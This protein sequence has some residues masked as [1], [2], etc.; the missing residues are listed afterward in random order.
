MKKLFLIL[1]IMAMCVPPI[2]AADNGRSGEFS[3]LRP[4]VD[5]YLHFDVNTINAWV[6]N[7]GSIF[8]HPITGD[9]GFEWP[10][11]SELYSVYASGLWIGAKVNGS[12]RVAVAEYS[13]EYQPGQIDNTTHQP[14]DPDDPIY[15]IYKLSKGDA[16]PQLITDAGG[17]SEVLG[18]QMLWCVYNDGEASIHVNAQTAPLYVEVQQTIFGFDRLG[19][20]GNTGF[21]KWL[22]INKSGN[23]LDDAY[24]AVWV[25]PDLGDSGDDFVGCDTS[26]SLGFCYN[27]SNNDNDYGA[28][29]PAVG[30]DF[31]QGPIVPSPGDTALVS[32]VRFPEYKNLPM[33]S[34]VYYNNSNEN[35]GNPQTGPEVYNYMQAKWRDGTPITAGGTGID[36][37]N[38]PTRF[39]FTGEPEAG[40]G[41]L[42]SSPADRRF[43]MSTG[44]FTMEPFQDTNGNGR[45]D[46][47]EPGVQ[48]VVAG[49][50]VARGLDNRN[51]VSLL[52]FY[53]SF[54]QN[55]YD[56]NFEI[57]EAPPIPEVEVTLLDR[58]IVFDWDN[59]FN[60]NQVEMYHEF[61]KELQQDASI[62]PEEKY[63]D[64]Q[65][66]IVYQYDYLDRTNAKVIGTY[67]IAD[68]L[69]N[70]I[71]L[72]FDPSTGQFIPVLRIRAGDEGIKRWMA[73]REDK[74]ATTSDTRLVNGK[75]YWFGISAYGYNEHSVP[76][77]IESSPRLLEVT[78]Q[79]NSIGT[80]LYGSTEQMITSEKEGDSDGGAF[81]LIVDPSKLNGHDYRVN[82]GFD[83]DNQI[84]WKLTDVSLNTVRLDSQ[85]FQAVDSSETSY[86]LAGGIQW[87]VLGPVAGI[88]T[89]IPGP[90]GDEHLYNGWNFSGTRWV[91]WED[92]GGISFG[93]SLFNGPDF[94][95]S[96]IGPADYTDVELRWAGLTDKSDL[97]G[98]VMAA[99]SQTEMPDRWSKAYVYRRDQ[100]Y[101]FVGMGDI[102]FS[103]WDV[104]SDRRLNICFVE[105]ANN[106]NAN[107]LWD[108][109]WNGTDTTFSE[110]GGREYI[111]IMTSDYDPA[112]SLYDDNNFGPEADVMY[113]IYPNERSSGVSHPYLEG[114]WDMQI[115]ASNVNTPSTVYYFSTPT[116]VFN[117]QS[118]AKSDMEKINVFPNPYYATHSGE[119]L[120]TEKWIE[121]THLPPTCTIRIFNLAGMLIRTLERSSVTDRTWEKW[122]LQNESDLPVASGIYIYHIE[123]PNVGEKTGKM[124]IFMPQER[125]DTF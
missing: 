59:D 44:P 124:A 99:A 87:K 37:N 60:F 9:S 67:D 4:Q 80:R 23:S 51:S 34:F 18:D 88:N 102:P 25:D 115:Y 33:T 70:I 73:V 32:G 76:K 27:S 96:T 122:N 63:F 36:P 98:E 61:N 118:M 57:P 10:K 38:P 81:G 109:G 35:N 92:H 106:G 113:A 43:M 29:P 100:G 3:F 21:I 91:S 110:N 107:M 77:V 16:V 101:A 48:E 120:L 97:T 62:P 74:F 26:L 47:G 22:V 65:G 52:K 7:Y 117:D 82:F 11:G 12:P 84:Y 49:V 2:W 85:Y 50:A 55:T 90:F 53:D 116:A 68:G 95:S 28:S 30:Y 75:R 24:L 20:L 45:P 17:P 6:T 66:Y 125:L 114:S 86:P 39:M 111:F 71:D 54:V 93:G 8:R 58:E 31:L 40:T 123:I 64:F 79:G 46:V 41:W 42:D 19:P 5:H 83:A 121:F 104:E 14:M 112:G 56:A 108:M 89:N 119:R 1:I 78:P 105:D 103:A 15:M 69:G 72:E 13:Y 94:F